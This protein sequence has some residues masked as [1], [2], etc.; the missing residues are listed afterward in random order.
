MR[1]EQGTHYGE[2]GADNANAGFDAR[3]DGGIDIIPYEESEG[4]LT[5]RIEEWYDRIAWGDLALT[6]WVCA[7]ADSF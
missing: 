3:P 1:A 6:G 7:F 5:L 4:S 2:A